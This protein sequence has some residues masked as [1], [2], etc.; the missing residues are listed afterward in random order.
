MNRSSIRAVLFD[1][2]GTLFDFGA[3][4]NGWAG[5]LISKMSDGDAELAQQLAQACRYNLETKSF[6]P[7][8]PVIAGTNREAAQCFTDILPQFTL[9]E[10]ETR[11]ADE[12][13][14]ADLVPAV[15]L[16]PLL[17]RLRAADLRLGVMTN[18]TERAARAHLNKAGITELF[19]F[20]AGFDSGYG[21]KP[22]P[23]PLL[24]F[25]THCGLK[26]SQVLMVGDSSHDLI[27]ARAARMHSVGVLTG[28]ATRADLDPFA[29][30]VLPDIGHLPDWLSIT[31]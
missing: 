6:F 21:A 23:D 13:A 29:D 17:N 24:A 20:V 27:A 18:D 10:L 28:L 22:D 26:P 31:V 19:D 9:E 8:S 11:L 30:A 16:A 12:A 2:D 4:W 1:K 3:T 14:H 5:R 7:D 15:P 25:A